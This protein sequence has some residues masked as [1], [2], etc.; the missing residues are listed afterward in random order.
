[1][2]LADR[3]AAGVWWLNLGLVEIDV[4]RGYFALAFGPPRAC[5]WLMVG[6]DPH[7]RNPKASRRPR[8]QWVRP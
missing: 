3:S 7:S 8:L 5:L 1:M 4:A 6:R 2:K